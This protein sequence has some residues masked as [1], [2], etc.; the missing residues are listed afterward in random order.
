MQGAA[1]AHPRQPAEKPFVQQ[2]GHPDRR[3]RPQVGIR[4]VRELEHGCLGRG[5]AERLTKLEEN[6]IKTRGSVKALIRQGRWEEIR[7]GKEGVRTCRSW[8]S[9]DN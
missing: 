4:D 7:E 3:Q 2:F 5:G 1:P 8:G 6:G 9:A